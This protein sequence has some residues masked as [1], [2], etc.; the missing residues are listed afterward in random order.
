MKYIKKKL[1]IENVYLSK[2]AKNYGTPSYCYSHDK[3]KKNINLFKQVG[4]KRKKFN[5][6]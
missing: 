3:L 4:S 1:S 2:I 5:Y 6:F